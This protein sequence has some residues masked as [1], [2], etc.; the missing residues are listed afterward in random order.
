VESAFVGRS[1]RGFAEEASQWL[2]SAVHPLLE[3]PY[4]SCAY[5]PMIEL[6][7]YLE[8]NGFATYIAQVGIAIL[9][10]RSRRSFTRFRRNG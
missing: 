3:R 9:C 8:A 7:R 4:L 6:L 2:R 5:V 1:V 10:A